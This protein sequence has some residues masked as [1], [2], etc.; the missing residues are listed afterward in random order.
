MMYL[1]WFFFLS[2]SRFRS[3]YLYYVG[4]DSNN[5][6]K[7]MSSGTELV[8]GEVVVLGAFPLQR[9]TF[10]L[11]SFCSTILLHWN[12]FLVGKSDVE[13]KFYVYFCSLLLADQ[14][15]KVLF[16]KFNEIEFKTSKVNISF[17]VKIT[18]KCRNRVVHCNWPEQTPN[19]SLRL[20]NLV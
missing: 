4:F 7:I 2:F 11:L 13:F 15:K 3:H 18:R 5:R 6:T 14:K 12:F 17:G 1:S 16:V 9:L 20:V 19:I 10:L 8:E